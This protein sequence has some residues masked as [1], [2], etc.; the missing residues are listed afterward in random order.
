M[1]ICII[2]VCVYECMH[3]SMYPYACAFICFNSNAYVCVSTCMCV[4]EF[5]MC[6]LMHVNVYLSGSVCG[7]MCLGDNGGDVVL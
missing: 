7:C 2:T 4:Y 6:M 3:L 1:Y 5:Y